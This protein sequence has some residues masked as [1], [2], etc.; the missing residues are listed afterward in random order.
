MEQN[1]EPRNGPSILWSLIFNKVGKNIQYKK[2]SFQQTVLGKLGRN[3]QKN[4][5][6]TFSYS[7]HK[8]KLKMD[9]RPKCQI[10]NHQNPRVEHRQQPL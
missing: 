8:N 5:T 9:E 4:E 10:G 7:I 6:G 2:K 3:M 1:R